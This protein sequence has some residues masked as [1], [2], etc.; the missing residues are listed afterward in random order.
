MITDEEAVERLITVETARAI[1]HALDMSDFIRPPSKEGF[2]WALV[3]MVPDIT[4]LY[5]IG[6]V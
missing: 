2:S 5:E 1:T 3:A 6:K 4:K